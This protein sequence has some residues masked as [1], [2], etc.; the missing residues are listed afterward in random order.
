VELAGEVM[1]LPV[2]MYDGRPSREVLEG[3]LRRVVFPFSFVAVRLVDEKGELRGRTRVTIK[4]VGDTPSR[5]GTQWPNTGM[6]RLIFVRPG[7]YAIGAAGMTGEVTVGT[8]ETVS[9]TLSPSG[10]KVDKREAFGLG[11]R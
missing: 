6:A 5:H 4:N 3:Q 1:R 11:V 7:T 10:L 8:N 2:A 9:C